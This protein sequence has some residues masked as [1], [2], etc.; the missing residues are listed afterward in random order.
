M[1]IVG[2]WIIIL[3]FVLGGLASVI[4]AFG[5]IDNITKEPISHII[6]RFV[7]AMYA[8]MCGIALVRFLEMYFH[9]QLFNA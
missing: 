3:T 2:F 7:F 9:K 1:E 4:M 5:N 8:M 6:A